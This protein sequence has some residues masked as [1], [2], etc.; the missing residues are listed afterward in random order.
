MR[1]ARVV[2]ATAGLSR[3]RVHYVESYGR[4][5]DVVEQSPPGG[6]LVDANQEVLLHVS[7]RNLMGFLP[8]VYHQLPEESVGFLRGL[9]YVIQQVF[10]DV[11]DRLDTLHEL[12]D[13]R[14]TEPEFAEAA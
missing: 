9:L 12:F 14:Q 6:R 11:T 10:D 1:D 5:L 8:Q 4:E 7:R 3:V 2:L 13:P